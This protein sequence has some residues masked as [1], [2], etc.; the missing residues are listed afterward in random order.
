[1]REVS[2]DASVEWSKHHLVPLPAALRLADVRI[3]SGVGDLEVTPSAEGGT[4]LE[5]EY[6]SEKSLRTHIVG[7]RGEV[8]VGEW[9]SLDWFPYFWRFFGGCRIK[10]NRRIPTALSVLRRLGDINLDLSDMLIQGIDVQYAMGDLSIRVPLGAGSTSGTIRATVGDITLDVP[11]EVGARIVVG[12]AFLGSR[13]IDSD[14]FQRRGYEYTTKGFEE[15][16]NRLDLSIH[17]HL[18]DLQMRR[19]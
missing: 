16:K 13:Y 4:L 19:T 7:E 2:R 1:M 10:L 11:R 9:A 14:A 12:P 18:G 6:E 15:A 5:G 17:S 8:S 3:G